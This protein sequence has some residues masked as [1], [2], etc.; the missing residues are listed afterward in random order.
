MLKRP[1]YEL[2]NFIVSNLSPNRLEGFDIE[3]IIKVTN[4]FEGDESEMSHATNAR[5]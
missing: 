3:S 5:S 2:S 1:L 4:F